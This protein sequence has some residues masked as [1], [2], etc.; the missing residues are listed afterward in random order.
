[1]FD[2][3]Y[4]LKLDTSMSFHAT[5]LK[6][7][8]LLLLLLSIATS[9]LF[10]QAADS[11]IVFASQGG[12]VASFV[13]APAIGSGASTGG[14]DSKWLKVEF[15]YGVTPLKAD[16]VD[17]VEFKVWIEGRDLLAPDA[18][19]EEGL[20]VALTGSVTY[21]NIPKGRDAYGVFYVHP[22]TLGR[23]SGKQGVSDFERKFNVHVDALVNGRVVDNIDKNKEKDAAWYQPLKAL[24]G[25][26]YRQNQSPFLLSD[27]SKYPAIK[28]PASDSSASESSAASDSSASPTPTLPP[29]PPAAPAQ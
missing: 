6:Q 29:A 18:P 5:K 14:S 16:Y 19:G 22:S 2:V 8:S 27:P 10:A 13:D 17:S 24:P 25:F 12:V 9:P 20:A 26:V 11:P 7:C 15:H 21:V 4:D 28:L 3:W 23:Y 1:M